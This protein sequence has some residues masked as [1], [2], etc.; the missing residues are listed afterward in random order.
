M[1]A[2]TKSTVVA[3]AAGVL[4]IGGTAAADIHDMA[5]TLNGADIDLFAIGDVEDNG[6]G[7]NLWSGGDYEANPAFTV[8][9]YACTSY[10]GSSDGGG[11][12][13]DAEFEVTNNS[14]ST[15]TFQLLMTLVVG[16]R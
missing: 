16:P 3:A 11:G 1:F 6:D 15:E 12:F 4:F 2:K 10:L 14:N 9:S 7:S 13:I 8:N 5:W